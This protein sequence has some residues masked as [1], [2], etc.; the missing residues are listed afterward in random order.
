MGQGTKEKLVLG[1]TFNSMAGLTRPKSSAA[2]ASFKSNRGS[3]SPS[4]GATGE[5]SQVLTAQRIDVPVND[6]INTYE[7]NIQS[8]LEDLQ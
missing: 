2:T 1:S 3:R 7:K 4:K 6:P 5:F 8:V